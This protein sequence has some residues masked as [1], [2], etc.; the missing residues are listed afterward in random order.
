MGIVLTRAIMESVKITKMMWGCDADLT[1]LKY[2][3]IPIAL[4]IR[5]TNQCKGVRNYYEDLEKYEI[6]MVL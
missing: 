5:C 6:K 3:E 1:S 4:N 2:Q